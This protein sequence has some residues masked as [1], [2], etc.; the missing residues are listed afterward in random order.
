MP[1]V[2]G[3][4]GRIRIGRTR[5][6]LELESEICGCLRVYDRDIDSIMIIEVEEVHLSGPGGVD[7]GQIWLCWQRPQPMACLAIL[8]WYCHLQ[9]R[10]GVSR[11]RLPEAT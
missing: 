7:A 9:S 10:L 4:I 6:A 1:R 5:F 2:E 8:I 3:S 11:G